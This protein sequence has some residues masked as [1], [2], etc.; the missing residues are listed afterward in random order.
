MIYGI[1]TFMVL[2]KFWARRWKLISQIVAGF[3]VLALGFFLGSIWSS[4]SSVVGAALNAREELRQNNSSYE[5]T[6]PLLECDP[7]N[8]IENIPNRAIKDIRAKIDEFVSSELHSGD[9]TFISIYFRD[10]NNGP[11]FGINEKE[12]FAPGSLLKVPLMISLLKESQTRTILDNKIFYEGGKSDV[13]QYFPPEKE[14]KSGKIY[15][16]ADLIEAMI[17]YSDN[18][19]AILLSK[20]L[21]LKQI[22]NSYSD[23]GID[24]PNNAE[25]SMTARTYASFFRILFDATYLNRD[26]SEGALKLLSQTT[27]RQGLTALLPPEIKVAH[28]FGERD[29]GD[30]QKQLHDCGIVYYPSQPYVLCVM[31]RGADYDKLAS[32]IQNI[33]RIVYQGISQ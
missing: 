23:L 21:S 1:H 31:T 24:P 11:W 25:Y 7:D 28:K 26:F 2:E 22:E 5:F 33:S 3:L 15:S 4:P 20:I 12:N 32:V 18:N 13:S 27:F 9:A 16:V 19:A 30:G 14:I 8:S 6:N 17:R 10:L 29:F